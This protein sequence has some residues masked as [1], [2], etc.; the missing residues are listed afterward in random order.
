MLCSRTRSED[1]IHTLVAP[2]RPRTDPS[3]TKQIFLT[4]GDLF[5]SEEPSRPHHYTNFA[6]LPRALIRKPGC[7]QQP[8]NGRTFILASWNFR[9]AFT[10]GTRHAESPISR[11]GKR[12]CVQ[13]PSNGPSTRLACCIMP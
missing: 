2:H 1:S 13:T 3:H 9:L 7:A 10:C 4:M 5:P 12:S 8:M 11:S 6:H